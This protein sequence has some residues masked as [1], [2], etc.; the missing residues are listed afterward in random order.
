[1]NRISETYDPTIED[2]Y[3]KRV[4]IDDRFCDVDILDTAGLEVYVG[5]RDQW[6]HDG[7]GFIL[8]YSI[9]SRDSF[10]QI[11]PIHKWIQGVK[12]SAPVVLVGNKCDVAERNVSERE[13]QALAEELG[14]VFVETSAITSFNVEKAFFDVIRQLRRQRQQAHHQQQQHQLQKRHSSF[15]R[16]PK[17]STVKPSGRHMPSK[18]HSKYSPCT[19]L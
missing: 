5:N 17:T 3:R 18:G 8:V 4:R 13:G 14:C 9:S 2:S 19:I 6:I 10:D 7:Q 12:L 15:G 1:L 16:R 11:V